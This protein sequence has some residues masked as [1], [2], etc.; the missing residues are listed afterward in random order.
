MAASGERTLPNLTRAL[1]VAL[2]VLIALFLAQATV[3]VHQPGQ[4]ETNCQVCQAVHL[5]LALPSGTF[6]ACV[7]L[8]STGSIE[9]FFV[10]IHQEFFFHDSPS[11]APPFLAS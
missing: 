9:P 4:H 6:S 11:R 1:T 8:E 7:L 3:H 10:S 2:V 5:G